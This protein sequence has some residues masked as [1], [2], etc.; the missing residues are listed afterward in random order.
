MKAL[1]SVGLAA[2][3]AAGLAAAPAGANPIEDRQ[4]AMK[5]VGDAMKVVGAMMRGQRDYDAAAALAAFAAMNESAAR[6]AGLFPEGSETGGDTEAA[7]AIWS[8]RAG[9]EEAVAK[10]ESDTAA[11]VAAAPADMDAFRPVFGQVA[12]NCKACHETYRIDN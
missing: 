2:C 8:D 1:M 12:S 3:L 9:F 6:Y 10:F 5:Q 7:P 11:A 4:A